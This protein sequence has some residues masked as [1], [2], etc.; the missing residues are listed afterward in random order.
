MFL[1]AIECHLWA[2][3]RMMMNVSHTRCPL[4]MLIKALSNHVC[5]KTLSANW[6]D[7]YYTHGSEYTVFFFL[8]AV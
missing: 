2:W 8:K 3:P 5:I 7:L 1:K 4:H 6:K